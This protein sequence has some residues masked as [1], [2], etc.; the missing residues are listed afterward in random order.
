MLEEAARPSR[1]AFLA[2]FGAAGFARAD[3][4]LEDLTHRALRFF[5]E[6]SD[7]TTGL[8]LDRA[9]NDG[10]R[11]PRAP[12]MATIAATGFA[13][14]ALAIAA[15]RRWIPPAQ[16]ANRVRVTLQTFN[17]IE[18]RHAWFFDRASCRTG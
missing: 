12:N 7:Q 6:Q 9:R 14:T 11:E 5:W 17:R 18:N 10:T 4:F 3:T 16:A 2:L 13:L 1:R 8:T 15:D